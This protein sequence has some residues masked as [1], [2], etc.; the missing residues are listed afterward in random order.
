MNLSPKASPHSHALDEV[1]FPYRTHYETRGRRIEFRYEE[2]LDETK[3]LFLA[4][5][6]Q[7]RMVLIKFTQSY[8]AE[9]HQYCSDKGIAPTLHAVERLPGNWFMVV[10]DYLDDSLYNPLWIPS[11]LTDRSVLYLRLRRAMK[12]LHEGGFVHGDFRIIN[13]M[14]PNNV[15]PSKFDKDPGVMLLDFDWAG[16]SGKVCY[17]PHVNTQIWRPQGVEDAALIEQAHDR[18]MLDHIFG[19]G[20]EPMSTS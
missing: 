16:E 3:L 15:N 19:Y 17:P 6:S 18:A 5:T 7:R 9:A 14:V 8:S 12:I 11:S 1:S 4:R 10:M 13:M 20:E 2:R